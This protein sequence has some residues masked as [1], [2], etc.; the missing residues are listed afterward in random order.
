MDE[1]KK[2]E[3]QADNSAIVGTSEMPEILCGVRCSI[4]Q[5]RH[6]KTIHD[7]KKA[8]H[9]FDKIVE[10]LHDQHNFETSKASLSRHFSNYQQRKNIISARLINNDLIEEATKQAAH[11][12]QLVN[13]IDQAFQ[14][15]G[16]RIDAGLLYFDVSDLEK[17]MK[18]RYQVM[19]GQ[20]TDESDVLAIFQKA[21]DKYGLNLQQG[22]L[23]K[24][25][26][27][28]NFNISQ[29]EGGRPSEPL[30]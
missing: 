4:C 14:M 12:K 13:L 2:T 18:L 5:S 16:A 15:I 24:P 28:H 1:N 3:L 6:L 21:S 25:A 19:S 20:D 11:T 30:P 23:F 26:S 10:I 27:H 9:A 29:G 7:L 22:I 17:L 8:G